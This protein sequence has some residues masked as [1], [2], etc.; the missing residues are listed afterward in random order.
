MPFFI[1]CNDDPSNMGKIIECDT[2]RAVNNVI[3]S[4]IAELPKERTVNDYSVFS[5]FELTVK[6]VEIV[7]S[8]KLVREK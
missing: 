7:K 6:S 8:I 3:T 2:E 5:G 4:R 1:L